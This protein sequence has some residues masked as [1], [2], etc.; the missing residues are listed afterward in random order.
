MTG[1]E[2]P[3]LEKRREWRYAE[4]AGDTFGLRAGLF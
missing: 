2:A 4:K 1:E 3:L